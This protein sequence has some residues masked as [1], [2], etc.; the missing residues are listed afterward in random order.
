MLYGIRSGKNNKPPSHWLRS[1]VLVCPF[2]TC[3]STSMLPFGLL[4]KQNMVKS[5]PKL[6]NDVAGQWIIVGGAFRSV[7]LVTLSFCGVKRKTSNK[8]I[9]IHFDVFARVRFS[10]LCCHRNV[11]AQQCGIPPYHYLIYPALQGLY[12]FNIWF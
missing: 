6:S 9:S 2:G 4:L 3:L 1:G 5:P 12:L 7:E 10:V 11:V 8:L